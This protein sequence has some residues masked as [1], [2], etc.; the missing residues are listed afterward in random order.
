MKPILS[1]AAVT[2]ALTAGASFAQ[3]ATDTPR[4][5][6]SATAAPEPTPPGQQAAPS[7]EDRPRFGWS[8][9]R[10]RDRPPPPP[11]KAAHFHIQDGDI[12]IDI[13]C[14]DDEPT[15]VCADVLLQMLDRLEGASSSRGDRDDYR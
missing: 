13:K 7:N 14:A 12:K 9:G 8:R 2:L 1:I 3:Q 15:K 10:M 4:S 5:P 11:S 6:D